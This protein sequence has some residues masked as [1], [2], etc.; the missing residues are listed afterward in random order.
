MAY[1]NFQTVAQLKTLPVDQRN[2]YFQWIAG[3]GIG[4]DPSGHW[5]ALAG[6]ANDGK[7]SEI[8]SQLPTM[9]SEI[10]KF[11]DEKAL[12]YTQRAKEYESNGVTPPA[13]WERTARAALDQLQLSYKLAPDFVK[14][15]KP[16]TYDEIYQKVPAVNPYDSAGGVV[17]DKE[18]AAVAKNGSTSLVPASASA[19]GTIPFV[20]GI[21]DA[22]KAYI[23]NLAATKDPASWSPQEKANWAAAT[24]NASVPN[25]IIPASSGSPSGQVYAD[26]SQAPNGGTAGAYK[27]D[28]QAGGWVATGTVPVGGT[29][30][31]GSTTIDQTGWSQAMKDSYA[32]YDTYVQKITSNGQIVNPDLKIDDATIQRFTDQAKTELA[33][34]YGQLFA[35][36][37]QDL[38]SASESITQSYDKSVRDIGLQYGQQLENTQENLAARGLGLGEYRNQQEQKVQSAADRALQDAADKAA[39]DAKTTGTAGE[40]TV[41]SD[42]INSYNPTISSGQTLNLGTPGVYG[43]T[44]STGSRSLFSATGGTTGTLQANELNAEETRKQDL[45]NNERNL[46]ALN[47]A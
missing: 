26:L 17:Y 10:K 5:G 27:Y 4:Y 31:S 43:L 37:D 33:P 13:D 22:D 15:D 9:E 14:G 47:Y 23:Q 40:R 45:I 12:E 11:T 8:A 18:Q 35:Q 3:N 28:T 2:A 32:A 20:S 44:S 42:K 6:L 30:A 36:A 7:W 29:S 25:A 41:G 34:Y 46:R 1:L 39:A 21:G 16:S 38:K 19:G 24:N